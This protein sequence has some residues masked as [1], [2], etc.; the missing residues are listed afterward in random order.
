E[1]PVIGDD[2]DIGAGAVI[3]GDVKIGRGARIGANAVVVKDIPS[4]AIAVG[5]P[6]R[7]LERD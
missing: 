4:G 2:V 1:W 7:I 5:V 3:L 6:A